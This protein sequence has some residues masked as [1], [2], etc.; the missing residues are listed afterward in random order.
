M[1][2]VPKNVK[3]L[4]LRKVPNTDPQQYELFLRDPEKS[5]NKGYFMTNRYGTEDQV[6]QIL[7]AGGMSEAEMDV[8]FAGVS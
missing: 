2:E 8:L 6:R 1:S 4:G 7:E 3:V 5:V